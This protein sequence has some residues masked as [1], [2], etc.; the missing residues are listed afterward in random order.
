ML[1][2]RTKRYSCL[3]DTAA[4]VVVFGVHNGW[5]FNSQ[6]PDAFN[7]FGIMFGA[8]IADLYDGSQKAITLN[9]LVREWKPAKARYMGARVVVSGSI[10]GWPIGVTWGQAV[11]NWGGVSRFIA[12]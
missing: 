1:I 9:A 10:W 4:G 8:D 7:Q 3:S 2:Q 5:T 6:G 11:R 12:P